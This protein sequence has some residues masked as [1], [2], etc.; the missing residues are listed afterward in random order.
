MLE[1][2][3]AID[4][5]GGHCVRLRQGDYDQETQFSDDPAGMAR[6]WADQGATRLHLVDLDAAKQGGPVN[7]A[8]VQAILDAVS[9]PCQLGGGL[10]NDEAIEAWFA[11]GLDRGIVGTA[12]VRDPKWFAA[13]AN[14][15]AGRLV[16]GLDARDGW[17][18]TEGWLDT[19]EQTALE[20]A[21]RYSALPLAAIV[22]TNIAN[23]GMMQGID[24]ATLDD[25]EAMARLGTPVIAS[26][27]VSSLEDIRNLA[28]IH[29]RQPLLTGAIV[30]RALYDGVF[31]VADAIAAT[32]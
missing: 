12:A 9:I 22:Y 3:P 1:I 25:L 19:S 27:G 11:T 17:V 14:R 8:A 18:A 10:R 15:F 21:E 5:R 7:V 6:R 28:A 29:S 26:G 2:L 20:L 30:G 23:D 31:D 24:A 32:E 13:A 16:L 4:L